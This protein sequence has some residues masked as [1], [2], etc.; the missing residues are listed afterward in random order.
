MLSIADFYTDKIESLMKI[1]YITSGIVSVSLFLLICCLTMNKTIITG[2]FRYLLINT[3][4]WNTLYSILMFIWQPIPLFPTLAV[5]SLGFLR[6]FGTLSGYL[7]FIVLNWILIQIFY[8]SFLIKLF[9]INRIY[10]KFIIKIKN[11]YGFHLF[12]GY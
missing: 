5:F 11:R 12:E 1:L 10:P 8:N 9:V 6:K 4:I 3:V 2:A 7:Q